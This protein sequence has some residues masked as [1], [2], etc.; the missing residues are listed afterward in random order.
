MQ[1][2]NMVHALVRDAYSTVLISTFCGDAL[3]IVLCSCSRSRSRL[4]HPARSINSFSGLPCV[5]DV[6]AEVRTQISESVS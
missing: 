2:W 1:D 6:Q 3:S 5:W 4:G